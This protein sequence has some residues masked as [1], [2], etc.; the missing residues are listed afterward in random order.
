M[1]K[2]DFDSQTAIG[3]RRADIL[4][5]Y[6]DLDPWTLI[7][8]AGNDTYYLRIGEY[9]V[10]LGG[11]V[12]E[13]RRGVDT[14]VEKKD[15]GNDTVILVNRYNSANSID[16][17]HLRNI[18]RIVVSENTIYGWT[19]E[20]NGLSNR[21]TGG[22]GDDGIFGKNGNDKIDGGSG[23]DHLHGGNGKDVLRGNVG[24]DWFDGGAGTDM[25]YGGDGIDTVSYANETGAIAANLAIQT[26][27]AG[28]K[29]FEIEGI[30]GGA[31]NDSLSGSSAANR[32]SGGD[33]NDILT[34]FAGA[35]I[36]DGGNG[37]DE[38]DGGDDDD[39]LSGGTGDDMLDGGAGNDMLVVGER[40]RRRYLLLQLHRDPPS[41][42]RLRHL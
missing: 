15:G 12:I 39:T 23:N 27:S 33:G 22:H 16:A 28:E 31:G 10:D 32:F 19:I 5:V 13:T 25:F 21:I 8:L 30:E 18:E 40:V 20:S 35:D 17:A 41:A 34:G 11:G 4:R 29:L 3:T 9:T 26:T 24:D 38:L 1:T 14:V 2:Y 36:L 7:G 42:V 6:G 37:N